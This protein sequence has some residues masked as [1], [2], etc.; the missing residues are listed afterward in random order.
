MFLA[1]G[2]LVLIGSPIIRNGRWHAGLYVNQA[3]PRA[4]SEEEVA[5]VR[6]I[7]E[8]S[9]DAVER[10]RSVSALASSE[11]RLRLALQA[12]RLGDWELD[13]DVGHATLSRRHDE[14]FG[15]TGS[16]AD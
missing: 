4:W 3:E 6:K 12:G 2:T 11:E 13:L 16:P 5:L 15:Y 8:Q 9:W 7:A 10:A 14:I 1:N